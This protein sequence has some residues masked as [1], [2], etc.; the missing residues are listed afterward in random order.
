MKYVC[1]LSTLWLCMFCTTKSTAQDHEIGFNV[2]ASYYIGD[3]NPFAHFYN[4]KLAGGLHYKRNLNPRISYRLG[5]LYARA[6]ASDA[7]SKDGFAVNRNLSFQTNI[8][9]LSGIVE[10]NFFKF[11]PGDFRWYA[12][13]TP[14]LFFGLAYFNMNPKGTYNGELIELQPLGT[15]GQGTSQNDKKKYNLNQVSIPFGLGFKFSLAK[16]ITM[17]FEYGVRKTFTDYMDDVS[18]NYVDPEV[19]AAESGQLAAEIADPS[20]E[21]T[22]FN[23]NSGTVRGNPYNKDWYFYAG[24]T[25]SI[26]VGR[27]DKCRDNFRHNPWR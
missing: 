19:L 13:F 7:D 22:A 15:E 27:R 1:L 26:I 20:I 9:E 21:G 10:V 24:G 4:P 11:Q 5:F 8:Y 2:G 23:N 25:L 16:R 17:A 14:Y 12:P 18:G 6:G 3:L